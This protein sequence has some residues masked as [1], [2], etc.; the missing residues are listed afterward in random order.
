MGLPPEASTRRFDVKARA[1]G[2][3]LMIAA[4]A[5]LAV[6]DAACKSLFPELS[7]SQVMALRGAVMVA[8]VMGVSLAYP[9]ARRQLTFRQGRLH[10]LRACLVGVSALLYL[11]GLTALPLANTL[12]LTFI[13]PFVVVALSGRTLGEPVGVSVW[14][15]VVTGFAGVALVLQPTFRHYG[16]ITILPLVA[17]ATIAAT[18]LLTRRMSV[19]ESPIAIAMSTSLGTLAIGLATSGSNWPIPGAQEIALV[20]V[21]AL[22]F[23]LAYL[24]MA[25]AFR[26]APA[27][28]V[29]VFRYSALAW[30]TAFGYWI[31]GQVPD[32]LAMT[33]LALIALGGA[34]TVLRR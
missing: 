18:D 33:G 19:S 21:A 16:P 10:A 8:V 4:M 14:V 26:T 11:G 31:W 28:Y 17:G 23:L 12:A 15:G 1:T 5:L 22:A 13:S 25:H 9:T 7:P 20:C 30:S 6:N 34:Y 29:S 24:L 27:P 2:G 32:S 3:A